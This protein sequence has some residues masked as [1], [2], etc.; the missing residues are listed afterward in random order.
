[1][2]SVFF[3]T[4]H[5]QNDLKKAHNWL[6][7]NVK[8][9]AKL[10]VG[11]FLRYSRGSVTKMATELFTTETKPNLIDVESKSILPQP[12]KRKEEISVMPFLKLAMIALFTILLLGVRR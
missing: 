11:E 4:L 1:M 7:K 6:G 5:E 10:D 2:R 8:E 12:I 9:L 3:G